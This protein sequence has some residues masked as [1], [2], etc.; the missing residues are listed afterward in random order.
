MSTDSTQLLEAKSD[1]QT[2]ATSLV[3]K[4]RQRVFFLTQN[5]EP[6]LYNN[7]N[8]CDPLTR[9]ATSNRQA[10][11]KIIAHDTR[12]V[13]SNGHC[14]INL[15]QSLP[16]FVQLR[17]TVIPVHKKI[18]ESWLIIDDFAIMRIKNMAR[19]EGYFEIDNKLEC[20]KYIDSFLDIWESSQADQNTRRLSL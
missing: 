7:K 18:R 2:C 1:C 17:T 4:A 11:I 6:L 19:Y 8:I 5:L 20:R 13:A 12:S 3:Q 9:L 10:D 15:A 14:L 16:S